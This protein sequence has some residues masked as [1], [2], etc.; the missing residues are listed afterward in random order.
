MGA[1]METV[2]EIVAVRVVIHGRVQGVGYRAWAANK[3]QDFGLTGWVRNR[4]EG[5]VE[6]VFCG[7]ADAISDM[8]EACHQGPM[9]AKV[10]QVEVREWV[11]EV[12][13][14]FARLPTA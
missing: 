10:T 14:G 3:A 6:A 8:L 7:A 2:E 1:D 5:T 12:E 13:E 4:E 9:A 11:D